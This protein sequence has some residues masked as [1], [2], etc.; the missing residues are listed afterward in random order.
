MAGR[1]SQRVIEDPVCPGFN[2]KRAGIRHALDLRHA[3]DPRHTLDPRHSVIIDELVSNK[4]E[5]DMLTRWNDFGFGSLDR[6]L[7]SLSDLRRQMD[8]LFT[9]F[10]R[11][12]GVGTGLRQDAGSWPRVSLHDA[13]SELRLRAELPGVSE[14][15]LNITVEQSALTLRGERKADIPEGYAV[16][17][18]ER[19]TTAFARSFALPS[20]ID[21]EKAN[22]TLKNGI[23]E[24]TLPKVPEAQPR[25][26]QVRTS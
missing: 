18:Q 23:L 14:K 2:G 24:L 19:G 21:A 8:R 3:L 26:I 9:D 22:A 13:G 25:Q 12:W 20:R 10:E 1:R 11:G 7:S 4:K 5:V 15:D 6:E 16:H 17:R